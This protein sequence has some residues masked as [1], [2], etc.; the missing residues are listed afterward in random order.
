MKE[1]KEIQLIWTDMKVSGVADDKLED[2]YDNVMARF[3]SYR[4]ARMPI[5][6]S[7]E[8]Q[9]L[10]LR[11]A[12]KD[13]YIDRLAISFGDSEYEFGGRDDQPY[14]EKFNTALNLLTRL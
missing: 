8:L 7:N 2:W 13:G 5:Y 11:V 12:L 10:R 9:I 1:L 14:P 3:R 4:P 6:V